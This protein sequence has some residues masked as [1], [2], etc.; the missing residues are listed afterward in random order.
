MRFFSPSELG[1]E[2]VLGDDK[3]M[4]NV[5]SVGQPRD[6]DPRSSYAVLDDNRV[7]FRRV[8]Y[9]L[10]ETVQKIYEIDDL[11]DFLGDRLRDGR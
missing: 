9:A 1:G 6:G 5:G 3:V 2:F 4:I 10:E 7:G 8:E 11:D